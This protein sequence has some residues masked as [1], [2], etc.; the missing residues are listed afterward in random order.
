MSIAPI[1]Q[2]VTEALCRG[3]VMHACV[4]DFVRLCSLDFF[5]N[6]YIIENLSRLQSNNEIM[7]IIYCPV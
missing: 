2:K 1:A 5:I 3:G 6:L 4:C 7:K